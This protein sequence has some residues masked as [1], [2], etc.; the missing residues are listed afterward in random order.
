MLKMVEEPG[1][2]QNGLAYVLLSVDAGGGDLLRVVGVAESRETACAQAGVLLQQGLRV[3]HVCR[4]ETG[5]VR[6]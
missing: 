6:R 2:F 4:R 3:V 5:F 1:A